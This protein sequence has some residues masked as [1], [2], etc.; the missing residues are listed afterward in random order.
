MSENI[1]WSRRGYS[2]LFSSAN[3]TIIFLLIP[4][5]F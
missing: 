5:S 2:F 3:P 1:I 4:N